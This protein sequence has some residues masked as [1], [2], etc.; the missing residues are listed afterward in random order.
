MYGLFS[1]YWAPPSG[2]QFPSQFPCDAG[3]GRCAAPGGARRGQAAGVARGGGRG[4]G[5]GGRD[6]RYAAHTYIIYIENVYMHIYD[7]G[8]TLPCSY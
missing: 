7:S 3:C 2:I 1:S 4:Q 5:G 6:A 8:L